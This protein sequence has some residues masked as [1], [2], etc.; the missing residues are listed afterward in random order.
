MTTLYVT[1]KGTIYECFFSARVSK[2]N[3]ASSAHALVQNLPLAASLGL[4]VPPVARKLLVNF[5]QVYA[6]SSST[7]G[8][9]DST[10]VCPN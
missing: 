2:S 8:T 3:V 6:A 1:T 7:K 4:L 5:T 9:A 10:L